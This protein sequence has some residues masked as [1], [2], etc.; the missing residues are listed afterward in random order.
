MADG[1]GSDKAIYTQA[2]F[3]ALDITTL[4]VGFQAFVLDSGVT[5]EVGVAAGS[6][7]PNI[8]KVW[9]AVGGG[10]GARI[11]LYVNAS[12]T[13]VPP[14]GGGSDSNPGS[15]ARPFQTLNHAVAAQAGLTGADVRIHAAPGTYTGDALR[16]PG[17]KTTAAC[18]CIVGEYLPVASLTPTPIPVL[19]VDPAT[20]AFTTALGLSDDLVATG[21]AVRFVAADATLNIVANTTTGANDAITVASNLTNYGLLAPGDLVEI[22]EPSL[23]L[24]QQ[25]FVDGAANTW[26]FLG[27]R[28]TR[29][30]TIA[31][32]GATVVLDTC[33]CDGTFM[34]VIWNATALLVGLNSYRSPR[35]DF[36]IDGANWNAETGS[37]FVNSGSWFA[38]FGGTV[39]TGHCAARNR[40][41]DLSGPFS[42]GE[43]SYGELWG[44][45]A[46]GTGPVRTWGDSEVY[47]LGSS[48]PTEITDCEAIAD[49][50]FVADGS[51]D[52][53]I[54]THNDFAANALAGK[55]VRV[56]GF[57]GLSSGEAVVVSN[58]AGPDSV[59][60]LATPL[61]GAPPGGDLMAVIV[62]GDGVQAFRSYL[63]W[64][65]DNLGPGPHVI[66][67]CA[68][69]MRVDVD[70]EL[71]IS[72]T[73]GVNEQF[74]V[75]LDRNS[76]VYPDA[77]NVTLTGARGDVGMGAGEARDWAG[78][79]ASSSDAVPS[80]N[81]L[82]GPTAAT[83]G[84]T[85]GVIHTTLNLA[86]NEAVGLRV[87]FVSGPAQGLQ[88]IVASNTAGPNSQLVLEAPLG[89]APV[90]TNQFVLGTSFLLYAGA[91]QAGSSDVL[92]KT[93]LDL[94]LNQAAGYWLF[95]LS[96]AALGA[97]EQIRSNKAGPN[98]ELTPVRALPAAVGAGD[99]YLL[100]ASAGCYARANAGAIA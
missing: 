97:L 22:V 64:T 95:V 46:R 34:G 11:D 73:E 68:N 45:S 18:P 50:V 72:A 49:Y 60:T 33:A 47:N 30:S 70:S 98:A 76:R 9:Q 77:N 39:R 5:W 54:A 74:G 35:T 58:T 8:T 16:L 92:V 100:V 7:L 40:P 25:V 65:P 96:G 93:T 61:D 10:Q 43:G 67:G 83:A 63:S 15:L 4:A 69:G 42:F 29:G 75:A 87:I 55:T 51:T 48:T 6:T 37:T 27:V 24:E 41:E 57:S 23:V 44:L 62:A 26:G 3:D 84:T 38:S 66:A 79:S 32:N 21:Y 59:L 52:T 78:A 99:I 82:H 86:E 1:N 53:S 91:A 28:F 80:E 2:E 20:G 88:G 12:A 31:S 89:V 85:A 56:L 71:W 94:A 17:P 36:P 13:P 14:Y 90:A 19:T 81:V